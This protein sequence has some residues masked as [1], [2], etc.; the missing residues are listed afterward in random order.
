MPWSIEK[1][2][3]YWRVG[4][5]LLVIGGLLAVESLAK[6]SFIHKLWPLLL[7]IMGTGLIEI[8]RR[9]GRG[10]AAY[11]TVGVTLIGCSGLALYCNFSAWGEL[12]RLWMVF[13]TVLGL[14]FVAAFIFAQR[15]RVVLLAG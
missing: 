13:I 6:L 5:L 15:Q 2:S 9:R 8:F 12:G 10:E 3:A 4:L 11:L 7:T 14:A 1:R